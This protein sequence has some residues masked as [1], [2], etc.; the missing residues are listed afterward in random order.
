MWGKFH[1]SYVASDRSL[2]PGEKMRRKLLPVFL[3]FPRPSL[4]LLLV[5]KLHFQFPYMNLI[6]YCH[7]RTER[8]QLTAFLGFLSFPPTA[9]GLNWPSISLTRTHTRTLYLCK[10]VQLFSELSCFN[11]VSR[12]ATLIIGQFVALGW[13][14]ASGAAVSL[15]ESLEELL[16]PNK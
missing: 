15:Q 10:F 16:I 12:R 9:Q 5:Y 11:L 2:Q 8:V 13:C 14:I 4:I 6:I 3:P 7:M 1:Y